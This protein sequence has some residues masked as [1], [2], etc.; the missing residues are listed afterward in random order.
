MQ[1]LR[2]VRQEAVASGGCVLVLQY[3]VQSMDD[4]RAVAANVRR[5]NKD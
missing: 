4:T 2:K 3:D 1:Q 5:M